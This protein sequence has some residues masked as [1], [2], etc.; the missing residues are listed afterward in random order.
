MSVTVDASQVHA[1]AVDLRKVPA[2][3]HP[4]VKAVVAK[5]ALN[6]KKGMREEASGH[7]FL[8]HFPY[9]I[10]YDVT[11]TPTSI[12]AEIGPDHGKTQGPLAGVVYFGTSNS[13]PVANLT[14]PLERELP[15]FERFLAEVVAKATL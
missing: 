15:V 11:T 6:V 7:R 9:T 4:Q 1:L 8:Q 5:G 13:G 2:K 12:E 3:V 14:G 10:T